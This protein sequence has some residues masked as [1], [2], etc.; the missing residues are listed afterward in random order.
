MG[1]IPSDACLVPDHTTHLEDLGQ[2]SGCDVGVDIQHLTVG[3]LGQTGK[4]RQASSTDGSLD[5]RLVDL[6][7]LTDETILGLVEVFGRED[8]RGDR[9][10][11]CTETFEGRRELEVLLEE[12]SLKVSAGGRRAVICHRVAD[13]T[14]SSN[15]EGT[16]VYRSSLDATFTRLVSLPVIRIPSS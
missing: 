10:C 8:T 9:A 15:L 6:G 4:D 3:V 16:G 2:L 12:H 5:R 1:Y 14:H 13:R 7:D 11:T